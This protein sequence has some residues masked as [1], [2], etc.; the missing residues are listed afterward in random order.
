MYYFN[1][2]TYK[3]ELNMAQLAESLTDLL[4]HS[5]VTALV[6][7]RLIFRAGPMTSMLTFGFRT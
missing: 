5:T 1:D 4:K 2:I 7:D 3:T 6:W